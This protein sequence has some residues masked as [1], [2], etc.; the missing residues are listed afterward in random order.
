MR[1]Q[2]KEATTPL[3]NPPLLD[4]GKESGVIDEGKK[5]N[6]AKLITNITA[7]IFTNSRPISGSPGRWSGTRPPVTRREIAPFQP[8]R[9]SEETA[10][11]KRKTMEKNANQ[12]IAA[13]GNSMRHIILEYVERSKEA[14]LTTEMGH[15]QSCG[16]CRL[17]GSVGRIVGSVRAC[18]LFFT[19]PFH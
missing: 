11:I 3:P 12:P 1:R 14:L 2:T 19:G 6:V 15:H 7:P 16:A 5:K 10:N 18:N 13:S 17:H 9:N 8:A 4:S